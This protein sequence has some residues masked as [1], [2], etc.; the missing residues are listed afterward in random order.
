MKSGLLTGIQKTL[1]ITA[2]ILPGIFVAL[3]V[4]VLI[5]GSVM[6]RYELKDYLGPVFMEGTEFIRWKLVPD[7]P[8][9]DNYGKLDRKSVV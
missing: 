6:D 8:S 1:V 7:F 9:F 5:T 4:M 3:P 2:L